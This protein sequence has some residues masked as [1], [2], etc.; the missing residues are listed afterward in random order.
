MKIN[1][2]P[3]ILAVDGM[4]GS[5]KTTVI[6]Y[7]KKR[8]ETLHQDPLWQL[9]RPIKVYSEHVFRMSLEGSM[10]YRSMQGGDLDDMTIALG[11]IYNS[12]RYLQKIHSP[13]IYNEYDVILID[14]FRPSFLAY[15]IYGEN[16]N[17]FHDVYQQVLDEEHQKGMTPDYLYLRSSVGRSNRLL[18]GKTEEKSYHDK[19]DR[20]FKTRLLK[21]YDDFFYTDKYN[22]AKNT[23]RVDVDKLEEEIG[24]GLE[25][26]LEDVFHK[27]LIS[28]F[29]LPKL[30]NQRHWDKFY[31]LLQ[32]TKTTPIGKEYAV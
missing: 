7:I 25:I 24:T 29:D 2:K 16:L 26:F 15:Q 21:G 13:E 32:A 20:S 30:V 31:P 9:K 8:L 4:D 28:Y 19:K 11:A 1:D 6:G 5:G 10:F 12:G 18:E 3:V 23:I 14:R 17:C 27:F 22:F